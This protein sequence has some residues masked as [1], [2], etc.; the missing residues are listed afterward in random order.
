MQYTKYVSL[1]KKVLREAWIHS[2]CG[3]YCSSG[4]AQ[5]GMQIIYFFTHNNKEKKM[6]GKNISAIRQTRKWIQRDSNNLV[7]ND[8]GKIGYVNEISDNEPSG[9]D[10]HLDDR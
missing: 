4:R 10:I 1:F 3:F 5:L 8:D 7:S 2:C 9:N 6:L